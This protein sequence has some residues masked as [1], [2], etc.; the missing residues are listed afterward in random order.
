MMKSN[1]M[2][3]LLRFL[4]T[5]LGAGVG[6]AVALGTVQCIRLAK[7]DYD[8]EVGVLVAG[9][10]GM[11]LVGMLIFFALS[12]RFVS[13]IMEVFT[14][15]EHMIDRLTL[16]Q[17]FA[18]VIGLIL[19]LVIASLL[20]QVLR[21]MG[22]S[23][24]TTICCL[25][26]FVVFGS[27]GYNIGRKRSAEFETILNRTNGSKKYHAKS[28]LRKLKHESKKHP[29][30]VLDSSVLIDGRIVEIVKLGFLEND[31]I[32]P[33]FVLDELRHVA[34]SSD[35][36]RRAKGRRGLDQLQ[37][38]QEL[39]PNVRVEQV[40]L[41]GSDEVDVKL[42]RFARKLNASIVT[43]DYNLA[44][45]AKVSGIRVQNVNALASALRPVMAAGDETDIQI[46]REGKEPG[47]GVGYLPD[48]TMVVVDGGSRS[49]NETVHAVVTSVLQTN[50]GRMIFAK[51]TDSAA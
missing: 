25:I 12:R 14:D 20:T 5:L 51:A 13:R 22:E 49:M 33:S 36:A 47:Q 48:G 19:G 2:K 23:L 42:L 28:S 46:I 17:V 44:K 11:A 3:S 38:L 40:D 50:A 32:A 24:F 31:L 27:T 30:S 16:P 1:G 29:V 39:S 45:V 7:P 18:R 26:L 35:P 10:G 4:F 43:D 9:Y 15:G 41:S 8:F 37:R 34:D 6:V 21:F